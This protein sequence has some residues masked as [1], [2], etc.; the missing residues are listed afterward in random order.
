MHG[1][2][3]TNEVIPIP[4]EMMAERFFVQITAALNG[5][6]TAINLSQLIANV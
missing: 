5:E 2:N 6:R 3:I 4:I 1:I